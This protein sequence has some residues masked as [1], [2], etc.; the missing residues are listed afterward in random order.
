MLDH[1]EVLEA[2]MG[3]DL[4][5]K[6][7]LLNRALRHLLDAEFRVLFAVFDNTALAGK[8]TAAITL[9]GFVAE[10]GLSLPCVGY[11]TQAL[12]N[13]GILSRSKGIP[14]EPFVYRINFDR[15]EAFGHA[16]H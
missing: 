2:P 6:F 4:L 8:E 10:T 11:S 1:N 16:F 3:R 9:H 5:G 7:K 13:K 15:L 12:V 14:K